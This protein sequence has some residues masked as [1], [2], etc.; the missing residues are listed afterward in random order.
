MTMPMKQGDLLKSYSLNLGFHRNNSR[1]WI[2]S[3]KIF[4]TSL[5]ESM[6]FSPIYDIENKRVVLRKGNT[7]T[8]TV[9]KRYQRALI[10]LNNR[11]ITEV[12]KGSSKIVV[13]MYE[14]EIIIEPLKEELEQERARSKSNSKDIT[15]IEV[16]AGG[17][18]LIKALEDAGIRT[19]AAVELDDR[20]L[21]SAEANNPKMKTFCGD[22]KELDVSLLPKSDIVS[23][24]WP[25]E[26]Y[27]ASGEGTKEGHK[28]GSLGYY[29]LK[30][31]EAIRPSLI[32][33]EEVP[34]FRNSAME[35]FAKYV[36]ESMG[37][38]ISTT[39]LI[40]SDYGSLTKR[41][42]Y[43]MIASMK[44]YFEFD[45]SKTECAKQVK[46]ILEVPI[47]NRVWL[48]KENSDT[49]A[50]SLEKEQ[51]HI[52]KGDG[53]RLERAYIEDS[54]VAT[55]TKGYYKNRLTDPI[56]VHPEDETK[57]SWFTP[58][59]LARINGLP[60]DFIIPNVK[61]T[62]GEIIGQ[63]V[64]YE[65]FNNLGKSIV[66]HFNSDGIVKK[67]LDENPEPVQKKKAK[68]KS[69]PVKQELTLFDFIECT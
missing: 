38:Y 3:K 56:L 68:S 5:A 62:A 26:G 31:I 57:F 15:S 14:N 6:S 63:G 13:K 49:I 44:G 69:E 48:D 27:S 10:D 21:E 11:A 39:N 34:D 24:G 47:E 37:Y 17:G 65:S 23:G 4:D 67:L 22:L 19:V 46:D 35:T 12:F 25:C 28:T 55:V 42:R 53:F 52:A 9:R 40:G 33:I 60:E 50:Y 29:F 16:F 66:R 64:C 36:L 41:N 59:E 8:I 7:N 32:L 2:E 61:T 51:K 18:T 43:C 58:R 45:D 20:Y 1:V 30:I 54:K